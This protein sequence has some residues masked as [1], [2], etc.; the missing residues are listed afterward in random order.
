MSL[1][2]AMINGVKIFFRVKTGTYVLDVLNSYHEA[3]FKTYNLG[4]F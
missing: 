1:P 2:L 3:P 4:N